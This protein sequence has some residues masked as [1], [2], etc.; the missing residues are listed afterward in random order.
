YIGVL[1][2]SFVVLLGT[3]SIVQHDWPFMRKG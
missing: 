1:Q 3:F 2:R